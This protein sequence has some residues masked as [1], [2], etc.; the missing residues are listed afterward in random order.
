MAT[1]QKAELKP[2]PYALNGLE[3]VLSQN[4]MEFHYGKHHQTYVNNLNKLLDQ[5]AEAL[6]AGN[7]QKYVD[8]SQAIKFNGG[9]HMNHEFFWEGLAP[10]GGAGLAAGSP[11]HTAITKAFGSVDNFVAHFNGNTAGIQGSGWGW[12]AY[13]KTTG[14]VEYHTTANQ[15]RLSDKGA[16]LVPLL[17]VDV[18]EHAYYLDYQNARPKFLEAIWKI[19]NWAKI[20]ER[21]AAATA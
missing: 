8:L 7:H 16:H 5:A 14:A 19:V 12:L 6:A 2:L 3:P 1:F 21:F 10:V 18:W 20:E 9:G 15:D 13:N 4:L 11:L 17:T